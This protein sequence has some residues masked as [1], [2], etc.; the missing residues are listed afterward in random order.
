MNTIKQKI[1]KQFL[2]YCANRDT[3][4]SLKEWPR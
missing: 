3:E 4:V 2:E 1:I